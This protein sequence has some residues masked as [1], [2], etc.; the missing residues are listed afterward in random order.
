MRKTRL[1]IL[2]YCKSFS[3]QQH[4]QWQHKLNRP[5][6]LIGQHSK[7]HNRGRPLRLRNKTNF[8]YV[9][10][11]WNNSDHS[12]NATKSNAKQFKVDESRNKLPL[13][14]ARYGLSIIDW[15]YHTGT[16]WRFRRVK[17]SF[18]VLVCVSLFHQLYCRRQKRN[19]G[20]VLMSTRV[21]RTVS[22]LNHGHFH[23][24]GAWFHIYS[25][26]LQIRKLYL[27]LR[28]TVAISAIESKQFFANCVCISFCSNSLFDS[29]K[30][31][32]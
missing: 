24:F 30:I 4:Q 8:A 10:A 6:H 23:H 28:S 3:V 11:E 7:N 27:Y 31:L 12:T 2:I 16:L 29:L 32:M 1:A 9:W 20:T 26:H 13:L 5:V 25:S 19:T 22:Q 15:I 21:W 14:S 18:D 17:I